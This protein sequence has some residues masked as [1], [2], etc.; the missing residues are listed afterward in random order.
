M[1]DSIP[2][3]LSH[4]Y[5]TADRDVNQF[6]FDLLW[7]HGF[8]FMVDP[9]STTMS[10]T[11][12]EMM[13]RDSACFV[14]VVTRR[15][16]Q[17]RY[18]CSPFAVYEYGLAV[19]DH[20]PRLV[21][22]EAGVAARHFDP[23]DCA[24]VFNRSRLSSYRLPDSQVAKLALQGSASADEADRPR[25]D[26][27]LVLPQ[28]PEYDRASTMIDKLLDDAGYSTVV[29][30]LDQIDAAQAARF[31]DACDF[32]VIDV[33]SSRLP[34]WVFPFAE[35]RFVPS[36]KLAG[37]GSSTSGVPALPSL[38]ANEALSSAG[39]VHRQVL[40][41]NDVEELE[42]ELERQVNRL[43]VPRHQF[44]SVEE[45]QGYFRSIGRAP[46]HVFLSTAQAD[47]PLAEEVGRALALNNVDYFHYVY[48]NTLKLG[49]SWQN[50]LLSKIVEYPLFVPL[51]SD[52]YWRSDWCR[53]EMETA[54]DL[55]RMGRIQILPY[56][57]E[58]STAGGL[59]ELQGVTM[60]HLSSGER[61]ARVL[62]DVDRHL[63]EQADVASRPTLAVGVQTGSAPPE[64]DLVVVTSTEEEH[65]ALRVRLDG[66][67]S[68]TGTPAHPN[69]FS[70]TIGDLMGKDGRRYTVLV[71]RPDGPGGMRKAIRST[72]AAFSAGH[73]LI[74]CGAGGLDASIGQDDLII[75]NRIMG[76]SYGGPARVCRLRP[77][78]ELPTDPTLA[79]AAD[80]VGQSRSGDQAQAG[81]LEAS[82]RAG[83]VAAGASGTWPL[84]GPTITPLARAVPGLLAVA[85][86]NIDAFLD[87]DVMRDHGQLSQFSVLCH[88]DHRIPSTPSPAPVTVQA[89]DGRHP[90]AGEER[91]AAVIVDLMSWA[92]P[93][94]S[95]TDHRTEE[96]NDDVGSSSI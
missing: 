46:G 22:L 67:L 44:Q 84:N 73:V 32:I 36:I 42:I 20:T 95:L 89:P 11:S 81:V 3:Y 21:F 26:V 74:I 48:H 78:W 53:K 47:N 58:H 87:L 35:G 66:A 82:L 65:R 91:A 57:L 6:F 49:T 8:A 30:D 56:F 1:T 62:S 39:S 2:T 24:P 90:N 16:D 5:R 88:V 41:W 17:R 13:M 61:V 50:R 83:I 86:E 70:W 25:G 38:I 68:V 79:S 55:N 80:A 18:R 45:G 71:A 63:V 96:R 43:H 76:F 94:Q 75:A 19:Q 52:A 14:A 59:I 40:W 9:K 23:E 54:L 77:D 27:G 85:E 28:T 69:H 33:V 64:I 4:S 51:L 7:P 10:T 37:I 93:L 29:P 60:A 31:F 34:P 72:T 12:L 92:R 15:D